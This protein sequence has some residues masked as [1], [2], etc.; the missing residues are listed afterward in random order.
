MEERLAVMAAI[1]QEVAEQSDNYS[2]ELET[3]LHRLQ[4]ENSSLREL[5]AIKA[6]NGALSTM[7]RPAANSS[8]ASAENASNYNSGGSHEDSEFDLT[9]QDGD[10]T[11]GGDEES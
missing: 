5:L 10:Q 4:T 1:A 3:E 2:N 6:G 11:I 9:H 8:A 7:T